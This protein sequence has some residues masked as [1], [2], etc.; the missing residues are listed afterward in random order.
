[1]SPTLARK[2]CVIV[3]PQKFMIKCEKLCVTI[4]QGNFTIKYKFFSVTQGHDNTQ[5]ASVIV[6]VTDQL[7][8]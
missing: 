2:M 4:L 1:M 7:T 6:H 3:H 8:A 5:G